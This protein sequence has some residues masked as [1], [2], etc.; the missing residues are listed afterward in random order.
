MFN[1]ELFKKRQFVREIEDVLIHHS[2]NQDEVLDIIKLSADLID[3]GVN[4]REVLQ[5]A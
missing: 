5:N 4:V 3:N 1:K 2:I